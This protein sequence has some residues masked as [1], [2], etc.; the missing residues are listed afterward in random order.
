ML[1]RSG[2]HVSAAS[3]AD[4][5]TVFANTSYSSLLGTSHE[6]IKFFGPTKKEKPKL[7]SSLTYIC[8]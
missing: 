5:L 8:L 2:G 7:M 1:F 4:R 3:A 6:H